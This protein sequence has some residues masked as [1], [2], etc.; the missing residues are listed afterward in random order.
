MVLRLRIG[1]SITKA[2]VTHFEYVLFNKSLYKN[3]CSNFPQCYVTMHYLFFFVSIVL[4][5]VVDPCAYY[6]VI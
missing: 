3:N 2:T 5:L 6:C 1:C 4:F